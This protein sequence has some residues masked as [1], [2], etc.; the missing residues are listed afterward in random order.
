V[1]V[2]PT[3]QIIL[4]LRDPTT[5]VSLF[6]RN[7]SGERF[8]Y[9]GELKYRTHREFYSN[10]RVQQEYVFALEE[11]VPDQLLDELTQGLP[12]RIEQNGPREDLGEGGEA[13]R[14]RP[15]S[16]DDYKKAFSYA[17]GELDRT[18]MPG[19]YNYQVRLMNF[20]KQKGVSG[21]FEKRRNRRELFTWRP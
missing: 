13:W 7:N 11:P 14:R 1:I 19:H 17:V 3:I 12:R 16:L 2:A 18:V 8:A 10:D 6:V 5:R 20:L 15:S 9:L 21:E 4:R